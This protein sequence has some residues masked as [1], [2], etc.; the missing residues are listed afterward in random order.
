M[1]YLF[2]FTERHGK[3]SYQEHKVQGKELA[4]KINSEFLVQVDPKKGMRWK[5]MVGIPGKEIKHLFAR[6]GVEVSESIRSSDGLA[7]FMIQLLGFNEDMVERGIVDNIH[8][9]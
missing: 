2:E 3:V 7:S 1:A 9:I 8:N 5:G 4:E 6:S